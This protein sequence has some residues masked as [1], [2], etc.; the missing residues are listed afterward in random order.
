MDN[1]YTW[2]MV[3]MVYTCKM[4]I[5]ISLKCIIKDIIFP[6]TFF[7]KNSVKLIRI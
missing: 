7:L 6:I 1:I 2:Y 3:Y 4:Y 5:Y